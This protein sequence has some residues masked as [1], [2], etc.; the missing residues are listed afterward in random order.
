MNL[1]QRFRAGVGLLI[2]VV[3][4]ALDRPNGVCRYSKPRANSSLMRCACVV[5]IND[6]VCKRDADDAVNYAEL[7]KN[8]SENR[9]DIIGVNHINSEIV[10]EFNFRVLAHKPL[11]YWQGEGA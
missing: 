11:H 8:L 6:D 1:V 9:R 4:E 10:R 3:Y 5:S 7:G 2:G